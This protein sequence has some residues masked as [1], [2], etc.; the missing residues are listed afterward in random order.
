M[1]PIVS[2]AYLCELA[3]FNVIVTVESRATLL[4]IAGETFAT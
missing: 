3:Y 1:L 2:D 4:P